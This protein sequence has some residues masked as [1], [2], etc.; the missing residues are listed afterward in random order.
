MYQDKTE[1]SLA[2][3]V[4]HKR[5]SITSRHTVV[6]F[7]IVYFHFQNE[8]TIFAI[9]VLLKEEMA[10]EI[11]DLTA[12]HHLNSL[13]T[14]VYPRHVAHIL[15]IRG[16]YDFY[17]DGRPFTL[18]RGEGM[19][20]IAQRL[21]E[22]KAASDDFEAICIYASPVFLERCTPRSNYG[23]KG[24]LALYSCPVMQMEKEQFDRMRH[25]FLLLERCLKNDGH[26]FY[27]EMIACATQMMILNF[28]DVH[29]SHNGLANIPFQD[30]DIIARFMQILERGDY[31]KN[32]EVS[33]Y[34]NELCVTPKYLSEVCKSVSGKTANYWITRFAVIHIRRLLQQKEISF[35]KISDM[36]GFSSSAYFSR[37]VQKHLGTSPT[38]FRK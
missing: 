9:T 18:S 21:F 30:A 26:L 36:F 1:S 13:G 31:I 11:Y 33:Y 3:F 25:N 7:F 5:E 37:F 24:S 20:I 15:C 8:I 27:D 32:R 35:T 12:E 29:A 28:F 4:P 6:M 19:I 22:R 2:D 10:A 38:N 16:C 14:D 34:A 23:I 17:F